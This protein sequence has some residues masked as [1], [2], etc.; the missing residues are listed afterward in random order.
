[1]FVYRSVWRLAAANRKRVPAQR[2]H[3]RQTVNVLL[4]KPVAALAAREIDR[5][6]LGF[7]G[8]PPWPS[9]ATPKPGDAS[10]H[11]WNRG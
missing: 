5:S 10:W 6:E 2:D 3:R 7:Q 8:L 1:M 9:P 11:T 4:G